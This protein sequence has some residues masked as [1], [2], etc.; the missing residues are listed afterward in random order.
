MA[1]IKAGDWVRKKDRPGERMLVVYAGDVMGNPEVVVCYGMSQCRRL[2]T[3]QFATD[4][5]FEKCEPRPSP[6]SKAN[7]ASKKPEGA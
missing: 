6:S 5:A 3:A 2:D 7:E 1:T 4:G